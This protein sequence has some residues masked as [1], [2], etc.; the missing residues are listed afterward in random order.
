MILW[1]YTGSDNWSSHIRD[2]AHGSGMGDCITEL[3]RVVALDLL[4][5]CGA[6]ARFRFPREYGNGNRT[7]ACSSSY[8]KWT[9]WFCT[10]EYRP[11]CS[12]VFFF[13][14][15]CNMRHTRFSS[16][17]ASLKL[18]V[19]SFVALYKISTATSTDDCSE[20]RVRYLQ[21]QLAILYDVWFRFRTLTYGKWR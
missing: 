14:A 8:K 15:E 12:C 3:P 9:R 17:M 5:G 18:L 2:D 16:E 13:S 1:L 6:H 19:I 21:L 7:H 11:S 4:C 10:N 20:T